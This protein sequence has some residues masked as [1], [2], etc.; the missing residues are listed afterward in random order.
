MQEMTTIPFKDRGSDSD[1]VIIVR[2]GGATVALC[3]SIASDGD[4]EVFM[5]KED[6]KLLV[7]ALQ[8]AIK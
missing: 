7:D 4:I 1:A 2:R 5:D 8:A 3:V 6:A